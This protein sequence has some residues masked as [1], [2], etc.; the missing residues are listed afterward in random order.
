MSLRGAL[1]GLGNIALRGHL[2][3]YARQSGPDALRIEAACD[4]APGAAE[5]C[6]RELPGARFYADPAAMIAGERPDFLD[7][8]AP[9]HTHAGYIREGAAAGAHLLCEKPLADRF[10]AVREVTDALA[11][12]PVVFVPCHQYRYSP[13]WSAVGSVIAGGRIGAPTLAQF[14]VYRTQADAGSP[15]GN[16]AWR[17]DRAQ[18]GGGILADTGAHYF[19]LVQQFFGLPKSVQATLR[20]LRHSSYGVEDTALVTLEYGALAVQ[21]NLTW[22]ADARANGMTVTGTE[23][24]LRYDGARLLLAGR[25]AVEE[26]PMPDVSDKNQYVG[27][28]AALIGEFAARI[29]AGNHG[30]DLLRE[31]VNVMKLLD[32]SYRSGTERRALEFR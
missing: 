6:R 23:G 31:S 15:A 24:S 9:P 12:R 17:T 13:L 1:I 22:A 11:G 21:V 14:N 3:A 7:I 16:P 19:Y 26:L 8:C 2:P 28:Y 5:V 32:L 27:W 30:D 18:S 25:S 10:E 29:R 20:T 4:V